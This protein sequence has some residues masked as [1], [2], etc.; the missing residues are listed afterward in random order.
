MGLQEEKEILDLVYP[1]DLCFP[2]TARTFRAK[3]AVRL[4][5]PQSQFCPIR[6]SLTNQEKDLWEAEAQGSRVLCH[7]LSRSSSAAEAEKPSAHRLL[8]SVTMARS[9]PH[10]LQASLQPHHIKPG[11]PSSPD[12]P[13]S[14]FLTASPATRHIPCSHQSQADHLGS[15]RYLSMEASS[16]S[17]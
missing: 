2:I 9:I 1:A 6:P 14:L 4:V 3:N 8:A 10:W 13:K 12:T 7:Q 5:S 17:E 15:A 16:P 11:K